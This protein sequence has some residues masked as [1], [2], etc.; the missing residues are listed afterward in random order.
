MVRKAPKGF[1]NKAKGGKG[2]S[3]SKRAISDISKATRFAESIGSDKKFSDLAKEYKQTNVKYDRPVA[4]RANYGDET[5]KVGT[6]LAST[7]YKSPEGIERFFTAQSPTFRQL[8]GDIGRTFTGY[9]TL[10]FNPNAQ[11]ISTTTGGQIVRQPGLIESYGIPFVS[12]LMRGANFFRDLYNKG[13][14]LF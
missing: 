8:L 12:T 7:Y 1:K 9:N 6:P 14:D 13:K 4:F 11:G 10:S 5:N 2:K 3:L